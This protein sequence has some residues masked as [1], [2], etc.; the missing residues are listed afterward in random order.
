MRFRLVTKKNPG[1]RLRGNPRYMLVEPVLKLVLEWENMGFIGPSAYYASF[2]G[3]GSAII[4][5]TIKI[6][7]QEN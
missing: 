1:L 6:V 3:Y 2:Y 7:K 5:I 4:K